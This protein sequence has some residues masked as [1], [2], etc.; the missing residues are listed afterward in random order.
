MTDLPTPEEPALTAE[1]AK[2]LSQ[3]TPLEAFCLSTAILAWLGH[4][5]PDAVDQ[6]T[7]IADNL[8][9]SITDGDQ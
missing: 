6:I 9:K 1:N 3:A 8:L 4:H 7:A 2:T 5:N